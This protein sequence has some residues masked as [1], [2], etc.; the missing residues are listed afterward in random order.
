M[1][2]DLSGKVAIVTGS[3]RGIGKAIA[4]Q[5]AEFGAKVVISSRKSDACEEVAGAL[6]EKL[7]DKPGEATPIPCH[8]S[9]KD[10]LKNL[11]D[12]THKRFGKIDILVGNAGVNPFYGSSADIPDSAF[13]KIMST[14][15]TS[16]HWLCQLVIPDMLEKNAGS[17]IIVSSV[18][19]FQGSSVL[20]TYAISKAADLALIR[21]IAVE[22]GPHNI[23]A[24]AIA[25]GLIKTDFAKAL[26]NNPET[27]KLATEGYP[28]RRI[29]EPIECAGAAVFLASDAS[30]FIT[31]QS[32]VI[33][34]GG[35]IA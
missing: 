34:G 11:V 3:T 22:Y 6:N 24:N 29:G 25:P 4:E 23:R 14:N 30:S 26:W 19:G 8:V 21:N 32:I 10:Q 20:G 16:N 28:L 18:A 33:D 7:K 35:L 13:E 17:I 1:I 9:H 27:L 5:M 12:E 15:I 2:F 31:G